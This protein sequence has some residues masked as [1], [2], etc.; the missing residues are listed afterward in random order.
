MC[1]HLTT[2]WCLAHVRVVAFH[3]TNEVLLVRLPL[4]AGFQPPRD[5]LGLEARSVTAIEPIED[6]P[7]AAYSEPTHSIV[8]PVRCQTEQNASTRI[9]VN[10]LCI[11]FSLS[12]Q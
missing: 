10:E 6:R 8:A 3:V 4:L 5:E 12:R 2:S 9:A 1:G 11:R 7:P